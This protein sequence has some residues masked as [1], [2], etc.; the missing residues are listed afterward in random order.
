MSLTREQFLELPNTGV[1]EVSLPNGSTVFVRNMSGLDRELWEKTTLH[2]AEAKE[3]SYCSRA[4]LVIF[5]ACDENGKRLF[6][7]SDLD[8]L[9]TRD[10]T[11]L[12]AICDA[13]MSLNFLGDKTSSAEK[14]SVT[15]TDADLP[16]A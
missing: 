5:T 10:G 16:T 2:L 1:K 13:A 7:E 8:E 6:K 11:V 12:A 4:V 3:E 9:S 14:N 15:G